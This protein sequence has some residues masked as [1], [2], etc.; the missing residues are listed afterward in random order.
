MDDLTPTT[1]RPPGLLETVRRELRL[2]N[3]SLKT[4]KAYVSCLRLF[5]RWIQPRHPREAT[6]QDLRAFVLHLIERE[7]YAVSTVNQVVNALRLLYVDLYKRPMILGQLP[8][9]KRE[10]KLPV[11][12]SGLDVC[13]IIDRTRNQ[14]HRVLLMIVY[15]AGLRVSEAVKLRWED[16]DT[17]RNMIHILGAK[18]K[19]DRYTILS[20]V[21]TDAL[22]K[23]RALYHP[24]EWLFEGQDREKHLS[25]RSAE[26]IFQDAVRRAGIAKDV[27]IHSL[28]HAFATHMLEQGTDLRYIQHLL[29]HQSIKTTEIYSHVSNRTVAKLRSPIEDI[30]GK[31]E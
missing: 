10:R 3:Y 14:K 23:Y 21:V 11:V 18:G 9:P 30:I 15:S 24:S 8:R 13:N 22:D 12:L 19:K 4:I 29:G 27:S 7:K 20:P 16:L 5:I 6:D 25:I 17:N 26:Y 31:P 28:R 2:R 1:G